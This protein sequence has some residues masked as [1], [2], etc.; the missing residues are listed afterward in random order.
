MIEMMQ[1]L[2][3]RFSLDMYLL[4]PGFASAGTRGYIDKLKTMAANNDRIRI[5]PPVS[6]NVLVETLNAYDI[7]VFL[8]PPVNFNYENTLPNKLF[9]FIQARLGIA[10]GPTPEM[11]EIVR[12]YNNGVVSEDFTAEALAKKLTT[13][14]PT[15][16]REFKMNSATA[17]KEINAENNAVILRK[18][19]ADLMP[20]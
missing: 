8:L 20:N 11:A 4:V 19:I 9:D 17:A 3:E 2:D 12:Q 14:T 1:Q 10:I 16:I 5:L 13:L 7:G 6:G 18:L 15:Q